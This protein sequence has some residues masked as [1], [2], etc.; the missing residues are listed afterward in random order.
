MFIPHYVSYVRCLVSRVTC[1]LSPVTC[2]LV[3]MSALQ[4]VFLRTCVDLLNPLERLNI[5]L[6]F[7]KDYKII[8]TW[9]KNTYNSIQTHVHF[10]PYR[11]IWSY[12]R[13]K[14]FRTFFCPLD[15]T[16]KQPPLDSKI[17]WTA[18]FLSENLFLVLQ[19]TYKVRILYV[20]ICVITFFF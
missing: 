12:V 20:F 14:G 5:T 10:F 16:L 17:D 2:Q 1:H 11:S 13:P 19:Q 4:T 3:S 18:D 7:A 6:H 8:L 15:I 9:A